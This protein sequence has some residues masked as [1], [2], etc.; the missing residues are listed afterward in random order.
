MKLNANDI[1]IL[2]KQLI[3]SIEYFIVGVQCNSVAYIIRRG[4]REV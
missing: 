3:N 4:R 1:K 2:F